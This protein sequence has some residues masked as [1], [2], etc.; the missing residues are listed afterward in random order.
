MSLAYTG[1]G[2]GNK[3]GSVHPSTT[4]TSISTP[5]KLVLGGSNLEIISVECG[6]NPGQLGTSPSTPCLYPMGLDPPVPRMHLQTMH[7]PRSPH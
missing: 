5:R 3:G 1:R 6:W 4:G 7:E 2:V